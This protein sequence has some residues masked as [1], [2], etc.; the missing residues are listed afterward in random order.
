MCGSERYNHDPT[1]YVEDNSTRNY[2]AA[3]S[4]RDAE[5]QMQAYM[6]KLNKHRDSLER[7]KENI[8]VSVVEIKVAGY[9]LSLE[10]LVGK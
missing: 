7:K 4:S 8:R 2:V 10:R 1:P 6:R 5:S 3:T 9:A